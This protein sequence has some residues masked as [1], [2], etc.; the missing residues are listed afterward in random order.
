MVGCDVGIGDDGAVGVEV[1]CT[2]FPAEACEEAVAHE[3]V[4]A[5]GAQGHR[6]FVHGASIEW[7]RG[8]A[9]AKSGWA[10]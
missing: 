9:N 7:G 8:I 5:A 1:S 10:A 4:V 2:A 3:D 6:D